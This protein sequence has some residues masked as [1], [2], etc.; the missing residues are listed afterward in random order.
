MKNKR[1]YTSTIVYFQ[2]QYEPV[3]VWEFLTHPK[4][5]VD[6]T[7]EP[8]F[9]N[10]IEEGFKLEK[11][12]YWL[13]IHTGEDCAGDN[14]KCEITSSIPY[15]SFVT[16]RHQAGIKNKT[17]IRLDKNEQGT[18]ISEEEKFS[19]SFRKMKGIHIISWIML[20]TGMLTRFS[21]KPEEDLFWF[22]KMENAISLT[23]N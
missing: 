18:L 10:E 14:V 17:I 12:Q 21:F 15:T 19:F 20:V 16:L 1:K 2:S 5:I 22:E 8:C 6:F 4:H 23:S 7:K 3:Q 11:D 13:E 9:Y